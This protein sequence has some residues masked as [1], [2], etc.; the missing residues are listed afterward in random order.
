MARKGHSSCSWNNTNTKR[1]QKED[2]NIFQRKK[3]WQVVYFYR[4]GGNK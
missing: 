1:D 4:E 2:G 3:E